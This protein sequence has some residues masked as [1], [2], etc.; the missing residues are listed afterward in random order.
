MSFLYKPSFTKITKTP[1]VSMKVVPEDFWEFCRLIVIESGG[2]R[3]PFKPFGYQR[4]IYEAYKKHRVLRIFKTR[5][6]GISLFL[7]L[8]V[9][10]NMCREPAYKAV[11]VSKHTDDTRDMAVR[12]RKI[13]NQLEDLG[14]CKAEND[15]M[16]IQSLVNGGTVKFC[17]TNPE[18]ARSSTNVVDLIFDESAFIKELNKT[19]KAAGPSQLTVGDR[20]RTIFNSTPNGRGEPSTMAFAKDNPDGLD[21]FQ[22]AQEIREGR[23]KPI[24]NWVDNN[25][26]AKFLIHWRANPL[27]A[28]MPDFVSHFANILQLTDAEAEQELNLNFEETTERVFSYNLI[29]ECF[30]L[31]WEKEYVED[32]SYFITVDTNNEGT[33]KWVT[34]VFKLDYETNQVY[35]VDMYRKAGGIITSHL[36]KT[37]ELIEKYQPDALAVEIT[38]GVG[39]SVVVDL[40]REFPD[41]YIERVKTTG[42]SKP[43]MI[44]D[45][46]ILMERGQ[47]HLVK[48]DVVM[49]DFLSFEKRGDKFE[50]MQGQHDDVVMATSFL[51]TIL[52]DLERIKHI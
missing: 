13:I 12:L 7:L 39:N 11:Y 23:E 37:R 51:T 21:V 22:K 43:V 3:I 17:N 45:L 15:N 33:D 18:H 40:T 52:P 42:A 50:A 1:Q 30:T 36:I 29:T 41:L 35:M 46:L 25:G 28:Q 6:L 14:Y 26:C 48:K 9:A 27:Y 5:Q 31:D 4:E 19:L 24:F 38:G 47:L 10:H 49:N 34:L 32:C 16:H 8:I 20:A 2:K 44:S